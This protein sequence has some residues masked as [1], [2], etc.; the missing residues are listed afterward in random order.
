MKMF[1]QRALTQAVIEIPVVQRENADMKAV[2]QIIGVNSAHKKSVIADD[3]C[4]DEFIDLI[5]KFLWFVNFCKKTVT[6][7]NICDGTAKMILH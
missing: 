3:F 2:F 1:S 5:Q 7:C 4:R 6:G